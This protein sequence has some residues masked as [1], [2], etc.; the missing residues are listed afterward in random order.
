MFKLVTSRKRKKNCPI[1]NSILP[2]CV[3]FS[4]SVVQDC[5][6][7]YG[8]QGPSVLGILQR[9]T[10]SGLPFPSPGDLS[11]PGTEP[12][13][14]KLQ[15]DSLPSQLPGKPHITTSEHLFKVS[16]LFGVLILILSHRRIKKFEK[17]VI[18][19]FKVTEFQSLSLAQKTK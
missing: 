17:S 10:V 11:N 4:H 12:R 3:F 14:P 1:K 13:S 6:Q 16:S 15:A 19:M 5:L 18:L 7:H 9:N 8:L 2:L